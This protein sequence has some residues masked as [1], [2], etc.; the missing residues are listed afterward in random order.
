MCPLVEPNRQSVFFLLG[1]CYN[2][3]SSGASQLVRRLFFGY[4]LW[5]RVAVVGLLVSRKVVRPTIFAHIADR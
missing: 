3:N 2:K 5:H 1:Q 4:F